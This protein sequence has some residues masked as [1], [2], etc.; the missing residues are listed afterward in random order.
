MNEKLSI[1]SL[2]NKYGYDNP[3]FLSEFGVD[4]TRMRQYLLRKSKEGKIR[5][6]D[7]GIYYFPSTTILGESELSPTEIYISKYIGTKETKGYISGLGFEYNLGISTQVPSIIEIT[8]NATSSKRRIV[9]IGKQKAILKKPYT[10]INADNCKALQILD[11]VN[12]CDTNKLL[13]NKQKIKLYIQ[14]NNLSQKMIRYLNVYPS[15][16][17]KKLIEGEIYVF[18]SWQG[19][20]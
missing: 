19:I 3:I 1:E 5:K 7:R 20:V 6:Y 12:S 8:T 17:Y 18:A 11:F 10:V 4:N 15:S 16:I 13:K 9:T 2:F 14:D